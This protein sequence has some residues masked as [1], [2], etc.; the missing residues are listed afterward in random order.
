MV[1]KRPLSPGMTILALARAPADPAGIEARHRW[2]S[3]PPPDIIP[4][5]IAIIA[6]HMTAATMNPA[7]ATPVA[8]S[9]IAISSIGMQQTI[10]IPPW[11]E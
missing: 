1:L 10:I 3:L 11:P 8:T 9:T 5:I 6:V 2:S 4:I 7:P